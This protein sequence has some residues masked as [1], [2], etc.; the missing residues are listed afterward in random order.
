MRKNR[1]GL[2][3]GVYFISLL[4]T[5]ALILFPAPSSGKGTNPER[6]TIS[7][8]WVTAALEARE[9][10]RPTG[11]RFSLG[12]RRLAVGL[13]EMVFAPQEEIE[14]SQARLEGTDQEQTVVLSIRLADG[15]NLRVRLTASSREP[16]LTVEVEGE[17]EAERAVILRL[18]G[19]D[20]VVSLE[21]EGSTV[22][23][24][25]QGLRQRVAGRLMAL[26]NRSSQDGLVL[27]LTGNGQG[28][29]CQ[30]DLTAGRLEVTVPRG[31][32][33]RLGLI[34]FRGDSLIALETR[35]EGAGPLP[36]LAMAE[37]P[38][39][40]AAR[41]ARAEKTGLVF[42]GDRGRAFAPVW[43]DPREALLRF[44]FSYEDDDFF[45]DLVWGA[46]LGVVEYNWADGTR[47]SLTA[48]GLLSARFAF[49]SESFD[50]LNTDFIFGAAFGLGRPRW[51][52][53]ALVFHQSSH[54]GDEIL[55]R[56]E[57]DR[58]DF[59]FEAVRLLADRRWGRTRIYGGPT[60]KV[61]ADPDY[62]EGKVILQAG[63]EHG[64]D[65]WRRPFF[66]GL[67]L[68]SR[69]END[70]DLNLNAQLG[71][72]LGDPLSGSNKQRLLLEYFN[73]RSNMGQFFDRWESRFF[74]GL[75]YSFR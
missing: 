69:Q 1:V 25:K 47:F 66:I 5:L 39:P 58:I 26:Q 19:A 61:R 51:S 22:L 20:R 64:F 18:G 11:V 4:G 37:R 54:L 10:Y 8:A 36:A 75:G 14:S 72:I 70:W 3:G 31:G 40:E 30:V 42:F 12:G 56:G 52:A 17:P 27:D 59:S 49:D 67:D 23:S 74:L 57:R 34:P 38:E 53:E 32:P 9:D 73:G 29:G 6:I 45:E 60:I 16:G 65:L 50:L 68:Q 41:T 28:V 21:G 63:F 7:S 48:R 2:A 35:A 55:D 46:D 44:G 24:R 71:L 43:A 15:G 33:L 62:Q 13:E